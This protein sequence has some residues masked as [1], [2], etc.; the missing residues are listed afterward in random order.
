VTNDPIQPEAIII[1]SGPAGVSAALPLLD[2]GWRVLMLDG[3]GDKAL[4]AAPLGDITAFRRD[5]KSWRTRFGSDL[6]ALVSAGDHSPKRDTPLTH[7]VVNGFAAAYGLTTEG[8]LGAGSMAAGGLS[9]IWGAVAELYE[10]DD[11]R[12]F[13]FSRE[14]LLPFYRAVIERIGVSGES[15]KDGPVLPYMPAGELTAPLARLLQRATSKPDRHGFRL[16]QATNAVLTAP[17]RGRHACVRC[18]LC[19]WGCQH[20]SIYNSADELPSLRLRPNFTYR[21]GA[22]VQRIVP[23]G[24]SYMLHVQAGAGYATVTAPILLLAAGTLGTSALAL[25]LLGADRRFVRLLHNPAAVMA[26]C[27]PGL[28]GSPLPQRSFAL[29]QL[30]FR[31]KEAGGMLYAADTLPADLF[32]RRMPLSR[33][34]ALRLARALAPAL[35]LA[36]CYLPGELSAARLRI[37]QQDGGRKLL[38]EATTPR[39]TSARLAAAG[40]ALARGMRRLRALA[41]PGS[42]TVIPAGADGHYAGTIPMGSAGP[43]SC[44]AVGELSGHRGVYIVDGAALPRLS[45]RHLTLTI[46]ANAS[47]IATHIVERR[48]VGMGAPAR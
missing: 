42:F 19:L 7:A 3:A 41:V 30:A 40:R 21:C 27:L 29:G 28:I 23:Q 13:P 25:D 18:G 44:S 47:R 2:A 1:G 38:I 33:P 35:V 20:K 45:A 17:H 43:V 26:F 12:G 46:M 16:L 14:A 34:T 8:F 5:Q 15:E 48:R 31:L 4:P 9:N 11:F 24:S 10:P 22:S 6:A 36:T 32:A 39:A 37:E